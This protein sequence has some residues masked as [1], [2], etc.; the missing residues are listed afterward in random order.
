MQPILDSLRK[1]IALHYRGNKMIGTIALQTVK[2]FFQI[3]KKAEN[4]IRDQEPIEGYVRNGKLF[5]KINQQA[6]KIESFKRKKELLA[7]INQ[8]LNYLGYSQK[9]DE[10]MFK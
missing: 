8:Q 7:R 1:N 5:L 2:D 3:E 6:T 10:I 9:I 4:I